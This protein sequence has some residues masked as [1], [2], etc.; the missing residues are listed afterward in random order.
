MEKYLENKKD[1][2]KSYQMFQLNWKKADQFKIKLPS[3]KSD[4]SANS[5]DAIKPSPW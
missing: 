3:I 1:L 4:W 2:K 5:N